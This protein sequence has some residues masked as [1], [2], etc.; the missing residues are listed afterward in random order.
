LTFT[1]AGVYNLLWGAVT[2]IYPWWFFRVAGME[3]PKYPEIFACLG[4][5]IGLYGILYLKVA[6]DPERE[7]LIAVVGLTG[8]LLG[9]V[10]FLV[11]LLTGRWPL[12]AAVLVAANDLLW[13]APFGLY[14]YDS[15]TWHRAG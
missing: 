7:W 14:L 15:W 2:A 4:M 6:V 11:L 5:V 12:S 9:P 1:A 13:W 10:G 8:K 3:A